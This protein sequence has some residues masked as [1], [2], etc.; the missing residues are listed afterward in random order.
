[1]SSEQGG[2]ANNAT[3]CDL[4]PYAFT[5]AGNFIASLA[6]VEIEKVLVAVAVLHVEV[7]KSAY[8]RTP[9]LTLF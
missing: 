5:A 4:I 1:M 9:I 6:S 7:A 3:A 8:V 2:A